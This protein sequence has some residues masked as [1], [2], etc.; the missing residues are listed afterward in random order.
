MVSDASQLLTEARRYEAGAL[1]LRRR[2]HRNPELGLDTPQT[3]AAVLEALE[4]L[5]L[6][7]RLSETTSGILATL[8]GGKPGRTILLRGDMDALPLHEETDVEFR[9]ELPG[10]MHACG[11]DAHTAMLASAARLLTETRDQ[12]V[13]NVVFMF[14]PGEE[15]YGG[16]RYMLEEGAL[17]G[18]GAAFALHVAP[19]LPTGMFAGRAGPALAAYDDFSISLRGRGGHASMPHDAVDPIPAACEIAQA[20]QTMVTRSIS[21]FEPVVLTVGKIEAG[22][23]N[24][25]IPETAEMRGTFRSLSERSRDLARTG[26]QRVVEGVSSAH[27]L[28]A[29]F[30]IDPGYPV[31]V[32]AGPFSAFASETLR[33]SFGSSA[34]VEAPHPLMGAEDFSY[35][36]QKV[37]GAMFFLGAR[38]A[39]AD[40]IEPC[41]S[42]RMLLNEESLP[43][44]VAAHAAI[45]RRYLS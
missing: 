17:D 27:G 4:P 45:A 26:L 6:E 20:L 25:V 30:Q 43:F 11:H 41:H 1:E 23:T 22:T 29:S 31:T 36:L 3:R 14:Q 13:G 42:N 19:Q 10:K 8:R 33:E 21:A 35:L 2:I 15:L 34:F 5:G 7:I 37:P 38:P 9:S 32:N 28:E 44:G 40:P 12:L 39:N 16:A 24:N 18:V